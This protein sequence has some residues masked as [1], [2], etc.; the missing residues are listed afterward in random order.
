MEN[1]KLIDAAHFVDAGGD[2]EL[3]FN[4]E[5]PK[6]SHDNAMVGARTPNLGYAHSRLEIRRANYYSMPI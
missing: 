4:L 3:V 5:R 6:L 1:E 2:E